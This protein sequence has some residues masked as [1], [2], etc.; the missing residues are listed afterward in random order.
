VAV[1][2]PDGR[3]RSVAVTGW[4]A[5]IDGPHDPGAYRLTTPTG[6]TQ[7]VAVRPDPRESVLTPC[8]ED[9]RR[10]VED[11]VG[12][13]GHIGT[14]DE[15]ADDPDGGAGGREVWWVTMLAVVGLLGLEVWYTR[16]LSKVL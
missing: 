14:L 6:R 15:I 2:G 7:Y 16:R 4:P 13:L 1:L 8:S 9:D 11:T 3:S 12:R 10:K 5:V